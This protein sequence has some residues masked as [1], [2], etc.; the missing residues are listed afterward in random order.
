MSIIIYYVK[1]LYF[2]DFYFNKYDFLDT[3]FDIFGVVEI[4]KDME[5]SEVI[6][7][8]KSCITS[9]KFKSALKYVV[10]GGETFKDEPLFKYVVLINYIY[11]KLR[12]DLYQSN[13]TL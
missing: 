11:L 12:V 3:N 5:L 7:K 6:M 10:R 2:S 4:S 9:H 8:I 1:L 13:F